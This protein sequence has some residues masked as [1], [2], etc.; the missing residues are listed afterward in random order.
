[1]TTADRDE[2]L[3]KIAKRRVEFKESVFRYAAINVFLWVIWYFTMPYKDNF[4]SWWPI[5]STFRWG[6]ML[7]IE[8]YKIYKS[9]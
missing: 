2:K 4:W 6:I 3:W 5:W 7:I 9:P 8:Y 1:M